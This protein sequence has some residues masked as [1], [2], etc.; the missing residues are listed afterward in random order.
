MALGALGVAHH[1]GRR[2]P[3]DIAIVGFDNIPE[4]AHYWP[5]LTTVQQQLVEAGCIAVQVLQKLIEAKRQDRDHAEPM[6][7][8]L[9]TQLVVRAS[10]L[11]TLGDA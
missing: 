9:P 6:S 3:Q 10:S 2:I 7:T 4:S 5:A 11:G 8:L 1:V